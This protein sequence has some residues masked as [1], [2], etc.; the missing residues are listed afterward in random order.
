M[1][2][3]IKI[4]RPPHCPKAVAWRTQWLR[5]CCSNIIQKLLYL[6]Y[7]L[8]D[9]A[10]PTKMTKTEVKIEKEDTWG[11]SQS[12]Q[13]GKHT[14]KPPVKVFGGCGEGL[15]GQTL[16]HEYGRGRSDSNAMAI[17]D[18]AEF[19]G[20]TYTSRGDVRLAIESGTNPTTPMPVA[21][22]EDDPWVIQLTLQ[23]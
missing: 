19:V 13:K 17:R 8:K 4:T 15:K 18:I 3:I 21:H 6:S 1:I 12:P 16:C 5:E 9:V 10:K 14:K 2:W 22:T 7:R 11:T 20:R 23:T